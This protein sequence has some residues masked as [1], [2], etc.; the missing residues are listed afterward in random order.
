MDLFRGSGSYFGK[1]LVPAPVPDLVPAPVLVPD[2]FS[3]SFLTTTTKWVQNLAFSMEA[4]L[5]PRNLASNFLFLTF[6]FHF[7]LDPGPNPVSETDP[8]CI[9]VPVP[10]AP[11]P[12]HCFPN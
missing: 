10:P 7:M 2:R 5:F 11:V 3:H 1:I 9:T 8:E 4:E 12:Q 6:E